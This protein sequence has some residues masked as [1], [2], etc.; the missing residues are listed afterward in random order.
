MPFSDIFFFS[1]CILFPPF[2]CGLLGKILLKPFPPKNV[3]K[4][5]LKI[6]V[7]ARDLYS[8]FCSLDEDCCGLY[9]CSC[10]LMKAHVCPGFNVSQQQ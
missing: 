8:P 4:C 9:T 2:S 3:D 1:V 5:R 10:C 6:S 7:F